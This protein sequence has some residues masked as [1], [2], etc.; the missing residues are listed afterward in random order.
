MG[1]G[2]WN[3]GMNRV[4]VGRQGRER[5]ERLV[6]ADAACVRSPTWPK[7]AATASWASPCREQAEQ[8]RKA[9]EEHAWDGRWY[10]RAYFDDGTP[11]GS[12]ENDECQIDSHRPVLGGDVRRRPTRS[13]RGRR[14]RRRGT[15][16]AARRPA[17]PAVHAA[18]RHGQAQPGYI[19]GYVPGI[20]ENGGQYTHAAAWVVQAAAL[21]GQGERAAELF[22]LL[23]PIQHGLDAGGR[24]ALPRRAVRRGRRRVRRAA[25][26]R[27]RRLDVVHRLGGWL[28]RAALETILGFRLHGDRLTLAPCVPKDWASYEITFQY[29]SATYRISVVNGGRSVAAVAVDG[30]PVESGEV[31]LEDDGRRHEVRVVL[32]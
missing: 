13:G 15:A 7:R 20:R 16:G 32:K 9:V 12:A 5:L 2:D 31:A 24:G 30:R 26:R 11:L 8:L 28:Y 18:V 22:D 4:G 29:R 3:D 25:A 6:P 27:P 10:R 21:L 23:N 17:D 14:W 19:K 1:T